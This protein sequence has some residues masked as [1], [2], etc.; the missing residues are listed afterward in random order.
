MCL[1]LTVTKGTTV[2]SITYNGVS[3]TIVETIDMTGWA[4][5]LVLAYLVSPATGTHNIVATTSGTSANGFI[6]TAQT[7]TGVS[8]SSPVDSHTSNYHTGTSTGYTQTITLSPTTSTGWM[9]GSCQASNGAGTLTGGTNT[10][11]RGT[12]NQQNTFD[13]NGVI[14]SGS[15]TLNLAWGSPSSTEGQA[16]VGLSFKQ[17]STDVSVSANVQALT[18]AIPAYTVT[19]IRNITVSPSTK[20]LTF[21]ILAYTQKSSTTLSPP[22]KTLSL[23]I[24]AYTITVGDVVLTPSVQALTFAIPAYSETTTRSITISPATKTL[25]FSIPAYTISTTRS[26][27]FNPASQVLSLV[28][29]SYN[30]RGDFWQNSFGKRGTSWNDEYTPVGEA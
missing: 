8:T 10:T 4:Y 24:P 22:T 1:A 12:N 28:I 7:F 13:T 21:S 29:P 30:V 25:S 5:R 26:V 3:M 17:G 19:A 14:G 16:M 20:A 15:Q 2:S 11:L 18:F 27:T 9:W 6:F 23:S